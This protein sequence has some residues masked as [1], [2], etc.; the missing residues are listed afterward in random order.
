MQRPSQFTLD[1]H[2][3]LSNGLEFAALGAMSDSEL[4][5]DSSMFGNHGTHPGGNKWET[6]STY[7]GTKSPSGRRILRFDGGDN[8]YAGSAVA[9]NYSSL[10][11]WFIYDY[12][13][14]NMICGSNNGTQ[15][16]LYIG[17]SSG[18]T[19]GWFVGAGDTWNTTYSG[20][21]HSSIRWWHL[22]LVLRGTTADIYFNGVKTGAGLSYTWAAGDGGLME[23]SYSNAIYDLQGYAADILYYRRTLLDAEV[24]QLADP[25]NIMLSGMI[26]TTRKWWPVAGEAPPAGAIMNQLQGANLGADLYDGALL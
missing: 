1:P 24:A 17:N 23:I 22:A 18:L 8:F 26:Q 10:A 19:S 7:S 21:N 13:L 15:R 4:V 14:A 25:S 2:H 9:N 12:A 3:H 5:Y 11:G 16:R 20:P 6:A